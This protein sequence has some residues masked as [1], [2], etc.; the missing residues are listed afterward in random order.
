MSGL[1]NG[2]IFIGG[3]IWSMHFIAM[4]AVTMPVTLTFD[5]AITI[6]SLV[7]ACAVTFIGLVIAANT[8]LGP[9]RFLVGGLFMGLGIASMHYLGMAGIRN[10]TP[11]FSFNG[12]L[13]SVS[14]AIAASTVALAVLFSKRGAFETLMA[15]VILGAAISTFHY[16][17]MESTVFFPERDP[18][19]ALIGTLSQD[20]LGYITAVLVLTLS[21]LFFGR[22][23][24][25]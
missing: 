6:L 2:A 13:L 19:F 14:I 11:A 10:C 17:A 12:V 15:S 18:L 7:V 5:I 9:L 24:Q 25:S 4:T 16:V 8:V 1:R 21:V 23:L 20:V 22:L 3:T